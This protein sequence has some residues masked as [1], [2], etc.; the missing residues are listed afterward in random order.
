MHGFCLL[1]ILFYFLFWY[2]IFLDNDLLFN[3]DLRSLINQPK[4]H[5]FEKGL[6]KGKLIFQNIWVGSKD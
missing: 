3:E 1:T 4:C 6:D 5:K 2:K